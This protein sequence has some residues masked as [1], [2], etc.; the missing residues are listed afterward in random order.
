MFGGLGP[1][2]F[3]I[4]VVI[5]VVLSAT[6][7]WPRVLEALRELRGGG[8]TIED[9]TA[10]AGGGKSMADDLC[11][12]MLGLSP[13]AKWEEIE[14]AYRKKAKLH[15]PDLGGDEDTMRALNEAYQQLKRLRGRR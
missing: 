11:F 13:S 6:G 15:H 9:R 1:N 10:R 4:F 3:L 5:V 14:R 8:E 2:E 7:L 12:R